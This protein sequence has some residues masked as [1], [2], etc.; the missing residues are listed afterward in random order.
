[1]LLSVNDSGWSVFENVV[2]AG[3][4][5]SALATNPNADGE[6]RVF[7]SAGLV[8]NDKTYDAISRGSPYTLELVSGS[9]F[10]IRDKDGTD[11]TAEVSGGGFDPRPSMV[12]P[13]PFVA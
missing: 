12:R 3:R 11:V 10:V 9:E 4:T 5:T 1:M 2:N 8:V 13:S 6:Q 7:L